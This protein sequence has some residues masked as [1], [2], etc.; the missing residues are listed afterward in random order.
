MLFYKFKTQIFSVFEKPLSRQLP[1]YCSYL[2]TQTDIILKNN[3]L[4]SSIS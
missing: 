1:R 3:S 4:H 2:T